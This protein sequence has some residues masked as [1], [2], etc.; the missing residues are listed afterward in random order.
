MSATKIGFGR[1]LALSSLLVAAASPAHAHAHLVSVTPR[2]GAGASVATQLT[3]IFSEV[4][5]LGLSGI[6][7]AGPGGAVATGAASLDAK[8]GVTLTVPLDAP[9]A[10]GNYHVEWHVLARDGHRTQ[11]AY[12]FTVAP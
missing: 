3:L 2:A 5:E 12:D 8:D 9:L 11:G 7:L 4:I 6:A 1:R 10:P